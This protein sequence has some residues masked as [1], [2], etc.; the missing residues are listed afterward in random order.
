[1][2]TMKCP[3]CGRTLDVTGLEPG[4]GITCE[5][6]NVT[7]VHAGGTSRKT[8]YIVL[9]VLAVLLAC[10][11]VGV[12]SAIAIPNFLRFQ[13]RA[14]QA[15]CKQNLKAW[16]TAQKAHSIEA[17][18]YEPAIGKV[19]FMPE[20]GNR[21]AYFAGPGPIESRD[22]SRAEPTEGA[23]AVNVDTFKFNTLTPLSLKDLPQDVVDRLGV[24]G[25]CPD[26]NIT[27]ACAG[28]IDQDE[29]LDV[30]VISTGPLDLQD[31]H[32]EAA[33]EGVPLNVVNDVT[34]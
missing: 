14:K 2:R 32:G 8:L 12:L 26:C 1:M 5:C 22:Q 23:V 19:G 31:E 27:L 24:S 28:N 15:E 16:Y 21:Y 6:G 11:C 3:K 18:A 7:S 29:A 9:G 20:R 13:A 33:V 34:N 10:P 25:Q 4:S 17:N 30:W